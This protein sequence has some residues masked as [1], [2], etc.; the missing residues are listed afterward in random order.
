MEDKA[1]VFFE[2]L[3]QLL[4]DHGVAIN[5]SDIRLSIKDAKYSVNVR[6]PSW[7]DSAPNSTEIDVSI[8]PQDIQTFK[9]TKR[10][11]TT[12]NKRTR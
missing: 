9:S 12:K 6:H 2:A 10:N 1:L 5:T 7:L 8:L 4:T 11:S 3:T